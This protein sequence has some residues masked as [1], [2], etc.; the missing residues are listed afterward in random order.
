MPTRLASELSDTAFAFRG[1]N[2]TNLGRSHELLMHETYG[3]MVRCRLEQAS[4]IASDILGKRVRLVE[5]VR[6]ERETTLRTY[7]EAIALIVAMELA[8][9]DI[10]ENAFGIRLAA[11]K[12]ALGYSLGEIGALAATGV[13]DM[14]EA[15]EIP[16]TM[17]A[18][19]VELTHDVTMGV[20][21]SRGAELEEEEVQRLCLR[22]N[23]TGQGVIGISSVLSPNTLL[24]LGQ[25]DTI[26]R[27]REVVKEK[28][29]RE[30]HLRINPNQW[31]PMHTPIVWQRAIPN[32][33]A[34]MMHTMEGGMVKPQPPII[35]MVT[36]EASYHEGNVRALMHQWIDHPQRVWDA[37][38]EM[39]TQGVKTVVHVG[40]QPNLIPATLKRLHDN[41]QQQ[42]SGRSLGS[43]GLRA[44]SG[45]VKRPWLANLLPSRTALLRAAT[46]KQIVLE[47]WLLSHKPRRT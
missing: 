34:V 31:P 35:S 6:R 2:V 27:F 13:L 5:R 15:L 14:R 36:G 24:L 12:L 19:C 18:D 39:L 25:G 45:I 16:L 38:Y 20:L 33:S 17:A 28:F 3:P 4:T 8:Q 7:G 46:L 41:V 23:Q 42:T 21:F 37:I 9:I 10:L 22:I 47:D 40:P 29:P 43:L 44:V 26:P 32:R 30:V 1:Y 11:G